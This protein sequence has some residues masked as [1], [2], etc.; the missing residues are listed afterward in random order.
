MLL[1]KDFITVNNSL[2]RFVHVQNGEVFTPI[3]VNYFPRGTGWAPKIWNCSHVDEY[4]RDFPRIR[5]LGM[6]IIRVFLSLKTLMPAPNTMNEQTLTYIKELLEAAKRHDIRVIFSGPSAWDGTPEW[7]TPLIENGWSVYYSD[8]FIL[9]QLAFCWNEIAKVCAP[10]SSLFSYDLFNEPFIPW[11]TKDHAELWK[12]FSVYFADKLD[13]AEAAAKIL[14]AGDS[15]PEESFS[16]DRDVLYAY[17]MFRNQI[18]YDFCKNCCDAIRAGDP[19]HMI[20][21]GSHQCTVPFDC[22]APH[23][24]AGFDPHYIGELLDYVSLHYYPY[25][26]WLD[27]A[28]DPNNFDR[29]QNLIASYINYMDIGKPIML[30]E[31]GLYGGGCA[32]SFS[33][34]K[35]F[36][37]LSEE[38]S[39]DW[40][41][42]T[43][44]RNRGWCSGFLNWGFD[45]HPDCKDPT[46]YQGF[47]NDNGELKALGKAI[48]AV[49]ERTTQYVFDAPVYVKKTPV[50]IDLMDIVTSREKCLAK[51]NDILDGY[52][53]YD[54]P[55]MIVKNAFVK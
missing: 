8:P 11:Q 26:D 9:E 49:I 24:Y 19:N 12:K 50:E 44:E 25:D 39:R 20:T 38:T 54:S 33:W 29:A 34:R 17:Q 2:Q 27:I 13:D 18:S 28:D 48:P 53:E 36:G 45:D 35:P 32:P 42:K 41:C 40:V 1:Q 43:I 52:H 30:E 16:I 46:R 14:A 31:F 4:E 23:R 55:Y 6:N 37:Y 21:V 22:G 5:E 7:A 47:Y 10:Y 3:G 15:I 51:R